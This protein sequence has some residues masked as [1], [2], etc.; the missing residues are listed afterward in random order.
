MSVRTDLAVESLTAAAGLWPKQARIPIRGHGAQPGD[1]VGRA[2]LVLCARQNIRAHFGAARRPPPPRHNPQFPQLA[3][4]L[5]RELRA[6]LPESGLVLVAGL[7][8]RS[9]TPDAL[10]V[11]VAERMFVTRHLQHA[12]SETDFEVFANLRPVSALTTGVMGQT[13]MESA[14]LLAAVCEKT[15][16][17][18]VV[19]IDALACAALERLGCTIQI[20]DSG[21]APGSGVENCRKEIS[22]RTM[23]VPVVAIGVPTVVDLHTAAEGMLQQELPPMQQ[24][25]W[26]VTPRE[27]DELVQHAA[28]LIL[29]GLELALYPELSFEEVSALL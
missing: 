7:G 14:E 2:A 18:C 29:C 27:I 15:K 26:M 20:C 1:G 25:N 21:I 6:F 9:I 28:D 12:L 19:V 5:G 8:N 13:G 3:E 17:A 24:E 4:E 10:G 22:A 23:Q 11:L 16:P